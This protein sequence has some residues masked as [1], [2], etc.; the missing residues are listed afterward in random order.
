MTLNIFLHRIFDGSQSTSNMWYH[1]YLFSNKVL[2]HFIR[3]LPAILC[4]LLWKRHNSLLFQHQHMHRPILAEFLE[5]LQLFAL[6]RPLRVH[7]NSLWAAYNLFHI[8][9]VRSCKVLKSVLWRWPST[10]KLNVDG[11][12]KGNPGN[13]GGVCVMRNR[14]VEV[15]VAPSFFFGIHDSISAVLMALSHSLQL[16][17]EHTFFGIQVETDSILIVH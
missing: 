13:S 14:A 2:D 1:N 16:C 3:L 5:F 6:L 7:T 4:W 17:L 10:W 8:R 12:Y 11:S 15:V 9:V